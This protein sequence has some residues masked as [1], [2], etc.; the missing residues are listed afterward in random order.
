MNWILK[1]VLLAAAILLGLFL[2]AK[3]GLDIVTRHNRTVEV[4]DFTNLTVEEAGK[5]ASKGHVGLKVTDSVFIYRLGAG[6]VYRQ[7]PQAGSIVKRG[8]KVFLTINSVEPKKVSM[9]NLVGYSILEAKAELDNRGLVLGRLTYKPDIATNRVLQQR[10]RGRLV[11]PGDPIISG[12]TIDL[13]L[14]LGRSESTTRVPVVVGM[15]YIAAI[16]AL[17]DRYLNV[18]KAVFDSGI[19]TYVD[20]VNAVVYKQDPEKSVKKLG[21]EVKLYLTLD[22]EKVPKK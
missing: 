2:I 15:K 17:H 13:T 12:S 10:S 20:S 7:N 18:G 5:V 19:H 16:D 9:P 14:G 22:P 6:V 1:N 21:T 3:V 8:R 11:S 4:P